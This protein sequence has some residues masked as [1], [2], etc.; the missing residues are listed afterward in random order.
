[1]YGVLLLLASGLVPL[2]CGLGP[3]QVFRLNHGNYPL[4]SNTVRHTSCSAAG[5]AGN[6]AASA[7]FAPFGTRAAVFPPR[8]LRRCRF[9]RGAVEAIHG[10]KATHARPRQRP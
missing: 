8:A 4:G 9:G 3:S 2:A 1:S 5:A 6:S 7:A 10:G